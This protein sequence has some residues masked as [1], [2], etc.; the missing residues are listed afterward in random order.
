MV[1]ADLTYVERLI[2]ANVLAGPVLELGAATGMG[3]CRE[4][5]SAAGISYF[6]T[7]LEPGDADFVADFERTE[8]VAAIKASTPVKTVLA[9]NV[10]EHTFDPIRVLDNAAGLLQEGGSLVVI[11]P[12][13]WPL[14]NCPVDAWRVMPNFYEQYASRRGLRLLD[15][16]FE[17][18]GVGRVTDFRNADGSYAFPPPCRDSRRYWFGR[19]VHR[20]FNTFGR[21]MFQPSVLAIGAVLVK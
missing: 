5:V 12:A 19:A 9:L 7:S 20:T 18:I 10:L 11:T 2:D 13:V 14:H 15:D 3:T 8:D 17:Y 4:L 1:G 16:Y 21:S 6:G